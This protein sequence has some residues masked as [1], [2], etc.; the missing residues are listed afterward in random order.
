MRLTKKLSQVTLKKSEESVTGKMGLSWLVGSMGH[1]GRVNDQMIL[2]SLRRVEATE[3]TYDNDATYLD[4]G[5][6][7]AEY[8]YQKRKQFSYLRNK[9]LEKKNK[10]V[11]I[12]VCPK[13]GIFPAEEGLFAQ[14][15]RIESVTEKSVG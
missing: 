12:E 7:S 13:T 14:S 2:E 4:S 1:F 9:P 8:S 11:A 10:W 15:S 6:D 3:F 5:K